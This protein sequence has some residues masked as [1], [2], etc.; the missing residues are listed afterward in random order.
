MNCYRPQFSSF[1]LLYFDVSPVEGTLVVL[2]YRGCFK[3]IREMKGRWSKGKSDSIIMMLFL[4]IAYI[5][6]LD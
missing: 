3:Q 4:E 2:S 6:L 1:L 5:R